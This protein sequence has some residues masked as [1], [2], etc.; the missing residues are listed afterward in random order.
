MYSCQP[1]TSVLL[2]GAGRMIFF[3]FWLSFLGMK[4]LLYREKLR[5]RTI[6]VPIFLASLTLAR[7]SALQVGGR[8][9]MGTPVFLAVAA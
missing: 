8:L 3:F 2:V 5:R 6:E 7:A 4:H 9:G 1:G